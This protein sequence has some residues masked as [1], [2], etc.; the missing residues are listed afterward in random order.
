[1]G[2]IQKQS[3]S[4]VIWSYV[5]VGLG[6]ITTAI[7]FTR[8]LST[9]EI[10]LL[11]LLVSYSSIMAM[12]GSLGMPAVTVKLFP[13][14]R[15]EHRKHHGFPG[16]ALAVV[17]LGFLITAIVYV[18]LKDT[19]TAGSGD[20]S[21]LFVPFFYVVVPLTLFTILFNILDAY[22]RVLYNAVKGIAYKEVYQR[23][24]IIA[25]VVVYYFGYVNFSAFVWLY[26]VAHAF[27]AVFLAL[28]LA[29]Q[30]RLHLKPDL[31]FIDKSLKKE[32]FGVGFFGILASF[33]GILVRSIDVIMVNEFLG[34][35]LTGI[36]TISFFFGTLILIPMRTMAKI[37][38]VVIADAWKR[39]D[40]KTI[41][42]VY[43]RSSLTLTVAGLL[44]FIGI[45]GNIENVFHLVG[46]EY[47]PGRYVIFFISLANLLDVYL[48]ISTQIIV[49]SRYY[50]W[51][52][53]FLVILSALIIITNILLIPVYGIVGAALASFISKLI[54]N[55]LKYG[56]IFRRF[57]LQ[58]FTSKHL[59]VT[60]L[61]AL[62]WYISTWI[63]AFSNYIV[64]II[65]R[66]AALTV[67]FLTP[68]Y[69]FKISDN[70]NERIDD[71]L[72]KT[73]IRL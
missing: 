9:E 1:M 49:N 26:V 60:A 70:V 51:L 40:K 2:I 33:S 17:L 55:L 10:G 41:S 24:I 52:T 71:V 3:I 48:G 35:S 72:R 18:L 31:S 65:V 13:H 68:V 15:D 20:K 43:T 11:R 12:I 45:W 66:S 23:L 50:R 30:G 67:L 69:Y 56:F 54:F 14:F 47:R 6:F 39:N 62:A 36:Y 59:V 22:M 27:P 25:A 73:G 21:A 37:G 4:G 16:L 19:L 29:V 34:L 28:S 61:A 46:E 44:F 53:Y 38:S 5:G 58:P 63:P 32:M 64:D 7:L 42:E 8:F 57:G